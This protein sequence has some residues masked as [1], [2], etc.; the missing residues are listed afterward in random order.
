[1]ES[2]AC[3]GLPRFVRP[4]LTIYILTFAGPP[5][6][7]RAIQI[8]TKTALIA[9]RCVNRIPEY[10]VTAFADLIHPAADFDQQVA[11]LRL[12]GSQH[13]QIR[14]A[15]VLDVIAKRRNRLV[16]DGYDDDQLWGAVWLVKE[17]RRLGFESV[18]SEGV[19][20][21]LSFWS[22]QFRRDDILLELDYEADPTFIDYSQLPPAHDR[23]VS[24]LEWAARN[25]TFDEGQ[26]FFG[27]ERKCSPD[28][29]LR[30]TTPKGKSLVVGDASLASPKHH[31]KTIDKRDAKPHTVERYRRTIGWVSEGQVVRCHPRGT[32]SCSRH[33]HW[34]GRI[35][36]SCRGLAIAHCCVQVRSEIPRQAVD[37][38]ICCRCSAEGAAT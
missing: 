9:H 6:Q 38:K 35:F 14:T 1:V 27:T 23:D 7:L 11:V 19:A 33:P 21:G 26:L 10:L 36:S 16:L 3:P 25:Q 31:G 15:D 28:Y 34:R 20:D 12:A 24:T 30:I 4:A 18:S 8:G 2:W 37:W 13:F 5:G 32:S 17:F 22:W 29:I